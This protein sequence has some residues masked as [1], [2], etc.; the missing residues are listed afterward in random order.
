MICN[1]KSTEERVK[2]A[3]TKVFL[4]KGF[5]GTTTR[6]IA[7]EAGLN[8]ALVNYY[9]RSKE[10][11]FNAVFADMLNLFFQGMQDIINKPISLREKIAEMVETD[12]RLF[13]ENGNL[14]IFIINEMQ[15]NSERFLEPMISG[16]QI[17]KSLFNQ[18]LQQGIEAGEVRPVDIRSVLMLMIANIQFLFQ[19]KV[20]TAKIHQMTDEEYD[21]FAQTH[22][23]LVIDMITSYLFYDK[24]TV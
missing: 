2:A 18:Q 7:R 5:D 10:K 3:A 24:K 12:F 1:L 22:K 14:S 20:I 9:F 19:S 17:T 4:E 8:S 16:G 13:K 23:N 21:Q 6:D 15:H 11:L